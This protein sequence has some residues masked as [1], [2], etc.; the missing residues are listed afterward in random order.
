M[1]AAFYATSKQER[2]VSFSFCAVS[3]RG[4]LLI[5]GD[6]YSKKYVMLVSLYALLIY[7]CLYAYIAY[8]HMLASLP[9]I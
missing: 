9:N 6:L 4:R 7:I 2:P 8:M 1:K 3:I 5:R